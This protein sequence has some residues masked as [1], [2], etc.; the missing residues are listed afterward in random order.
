MHQWEIYLFGLWRSF[1][2][3]MPNAA[4][5]LNLRRRRL[6][7]RQLAAAFESQFAVNPAVFEASQGGSK[8]PHSKGFAS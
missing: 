3:G 4:Q 7:V 1:A 6:G 8:L 2:G 5:F